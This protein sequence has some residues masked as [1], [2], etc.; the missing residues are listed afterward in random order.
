MKNAELARVILSEAKRRP[1]VSSSSEA[2][3][4]GGSCSVN[5]IPMLRIALRVRLR[6][7]P[8]AQ[9][10]RKKPSVAKAERIENGKL[11]VESAECLGS[12]VIPGAATK[13]KGKG[14]SLM[15]LTDF[16]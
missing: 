4:L 16:D 13:P 1:A 2:K 6:A 3:D 15:I 8:S 12:R 9:D 7:T 5:E 11:K 10:D 14:G